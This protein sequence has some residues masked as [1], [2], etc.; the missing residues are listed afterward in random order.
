MITVPEMLVPTK[1]T[2]LI[3]IFVDYSKNRIVAIT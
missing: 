1:Y 3:K 2:Y